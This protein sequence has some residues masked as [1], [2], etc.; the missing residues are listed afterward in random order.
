MIKN[1][2]VAFV[3][4]VVL[5][6][7]FWNLLDFIWATLITKNPYRFSAGT[8]LGFPLVIAL[9]IGYLLFLRD[10]SK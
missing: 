5:F 3:I 6:M 8:D 9:V 7:I 1:R 4:F 2:T 10:S